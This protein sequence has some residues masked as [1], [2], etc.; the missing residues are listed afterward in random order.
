[1]RDDRPGRGTRLLA[2]LAACLPAAEAAAQTPTLPVVVPAPVVEPAGVPWPVPHCGHRRHLG[3]KHYRVAPTPLGASLYATNRTQVAQGTAA[4]MMLRS[5][6][7]LDGSAELKPEARGR[8][9]WI[10]S[11]YGRVPGAM[12]LV[13]ATP[14]LPG[15]DEARRATVAEALATIAP[16]VPPDQVVI[17]RDAAIGLR[18]MEARLIDAAQLGRVA[19]EGPPVGDSTGPGAFAGGSPLGG[20]DLSGR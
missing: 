10:A 1:M 20:L 13:E 9:A 14:R 8:L 3:R 19:A 4:R 17:A 2:T 12:I 16:A 7:F 18:G 11:Q 6:D 15:L 5:Y